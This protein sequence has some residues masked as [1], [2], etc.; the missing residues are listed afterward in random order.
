LPFEFL[1][2]SVSQ[3]TPG[4]V[5]AVVSADGESVPAKPFALQLFPERALKEQQPAGWALFDPVGKTSKALA[6]GGLKLPALEADGTLPRNLKVLVIGCN[7]SNRLLARAFS[8]ARR[9]RRGRPS[10]RRF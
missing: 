4:E 5:T 1:A 8:L 6:A 2:P 10:G 9:T 7:A 3:R